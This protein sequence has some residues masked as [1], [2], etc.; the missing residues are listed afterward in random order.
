MF[1]RG[2]NK[3]RFK[4]RDLPHWDIPDRR[5]TLI[6]RL[7]DSIPQSKIQEIKRLAAENKWDTGDYTLRRL[8][9]ESLHHGYGCGLLKYPEIAKIVL[10]TWL[11][12]D[13]KAYDLYEWVIM[14][15]HVHLLFRPYPG[16][17]LPDIVKSWKSITS[18]NIRK[19]DIYRQATKDYPIDMKHAVWSLD[20]YDR[21]IRS[22]S[23]YS[24]TKKY[25]LNNPVGLQWNGKPVEK[26]EDWAF[27][28]ASNLWK[29][30]F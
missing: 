10:Q 14:P 22:N 8:M 27:S 18:L 5:Q 4:R 19:T 3:Y 17:T 20:Y 23:H 16:Y 21:A 15:N 13:G 28:S 12:F 29:E 25:I 2:I 11:K 1:Y 24:I 30:F 7:W 26:P 6:Y 9:E